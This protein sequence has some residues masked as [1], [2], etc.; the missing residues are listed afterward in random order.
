MIFKKILY[1]ISNLIAIIKLIP[2]FS[3]LRLEKKIAKIFLENGLTLSCAESCTGGLISSRLTDVSGSS[4]FI[5]QN[6]V[7]YAN[8]A[9]EEYLGVSKIT[10][11]ENGAVSEEVAKEMSEGLIKKTNCDIALSITGIA[12]PAG[13]SKTKPVGLVYIAIS[14][15]KTTKII[16]FNANKRLSRRIIKYIFSQTALK[17]LLLFLKDN[18]EGKK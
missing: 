4:G 7:T 3:G 8:E 12:G 9:K 14:N 15:K 16:K 6:F 2:C 10:L 11:I 17:G 5:D 1:T 13:E 18:H